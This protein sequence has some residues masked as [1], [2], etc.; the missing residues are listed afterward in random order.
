MTNKE[1][2]YQKETRRRE[3]ELLR[4]TGDDFLL[5]YDEKTASD[6]LAHLNRVAN[7]LK[8]KI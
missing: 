6:E 4:I 8:L 2:I 5:N 7:E 1:K 3:N